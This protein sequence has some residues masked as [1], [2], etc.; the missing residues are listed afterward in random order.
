MIVAAEEGCR[1]CSRD[2]RV[3]AEDIGCMVDIGAVEE[4]SAA[5]VVRSWYRERLE[6][7][8]FIILLVGLI[9]DSDKMFILATEVGP[10]RHH[11]EDGFR[12][13]Q[14]SSVVSHDDL[15]L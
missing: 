13:L 1:F 5:V 14:R 2:R 10:S 8:I 3:D 4:L 7:T 6:N 9:E 11:G 12:D 15:L